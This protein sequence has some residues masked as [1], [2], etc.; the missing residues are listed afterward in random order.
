MKLSLVSAQGGV[1]RVRC[2]GDINVELNNMK[3]N[4]IEETLGM[5]C[6]G[7]M[8]LLDLERATHMNSTGVAWMIRC[9]KNF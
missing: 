7:N 6:Y 4:P 2:E 1:V 9:H 8:V 5:G 3:N